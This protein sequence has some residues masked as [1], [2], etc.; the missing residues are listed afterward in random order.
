[1]ALN[2]FTYLTVDDPAAPSVVWLVQIYTKTPGTMSDP[3]LGLVQ[4]FT[5]PININSF[6]PVFV[7]GNL[8]DVTALP[9]T[10]QYWLKL[11]SFDGSAEFLYIQP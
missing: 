11:Y 4:I 1:M 6:L 7:P 5:D 10:E 3:F 2:T 9:A 8:V